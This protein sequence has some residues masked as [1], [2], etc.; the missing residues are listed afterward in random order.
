ML[1]SDD[2]SIDFGELHGL[3]DFIR[4]PGTLGGPVTSVQILPPFHCRAWRV[5]D[6]VISSY[7]DLLITENS[8]NLGP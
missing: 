6:F 7:F 1:H 5:A 3:R 8:Q 2:L 4:G